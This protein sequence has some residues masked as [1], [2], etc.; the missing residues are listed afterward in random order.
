MN[1]F[2]ECC[3]KNGNT[4]FPC[5]FQ[6]GTIVSNY[7]YSDLYFTPY[8]FLSPSNMI[9]NLTISKDSRISNATSFAFISGQGT[10][11][12]NLIGPT[13]IVQPSEN[14]TIRI[15]LT[16]QSFANSTFT[17][18]ITGC[19][20]MFCILGRTDWD[21]INIKVSNVTLTSDGKF[22]VTQT[23]YNRA[24]G[25]YTQNSIDIQVD[26]LPTLGQFSVLPSSGYAWV[27]NF[28]LQAASFSLPQGVVY[29]QFGFIQSDTG[30][31]TPL[32]S[33]RITSSITT[34]LPSL[35]N[36]V[37]EV[38]VRALNQ[39]GGY[40]QAS[41]I[42]KVTQAPGITSLSVLEK[43]N[44][45]KLT[46]DVYDPSS[47]LMQAALGSLLLSQKNDTSLRPNTSYPSDY[48]PCNGNG[49]WITGKGCQCN[50][51]YRKRLD[52]SLSDEQ[53]SNESKLAVTIIS[54][55]ANL[56]SVEPSKSKYSTIFNTMV[57]ILSKSDLLNK[58]IK[59]QARNIIEA[60]L[61]NTTDIY[62]T[63]LAQAID[64]VAFISSGQQGLNDFTQ[65]SRMISMLSSMQSN[66]GNSIKGNETTKSNMTNFNL[67]TA[68]L[69]GS[70]NI[71]INMSNIQFPNSLAFLNNTDNYVRISVVEWKIPVYSWIS[72]YSNIKTG[73]TSIN[74][75]GITGN[76]TNITN[77]SQPINIT[78]PIDVSQMS[79]KNLTWTK[80]MY[81]DNK[82]N[83]FITSGM[84]LLRIDLNQSLG[85]CQTTHL[86]DFAM[87]IPIPLPYSG[88]IPIYVPPVILNPTTSIYEVHRSP[89]FWFTIS[90]T[91]ILG[92]L[93]CW[94]YCKERSENEL[95]KLMRSKQYVEQKDLFQDRTESAPIKGETKVE[96]VVDQE[97][98][99][100][101]LEKGAGE[102]KPIAVP[103]GMNESSMQAENSKIELQE[104]TFKDPSASPENK[105]DDLG[106]A[107]PESG[108]EN[109][110][111]RKKKGRKKQKGDMPLSTS[112]PPMATEQH[113]S[114][115][116]MKSGSG[117]Q[118][119]IPHPPSSLLIF[120]VTIILN[121]IDG[122]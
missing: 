38:A 73:I 59:T 109:K 122:A 100:A 7:S 50:Y 86:S 17:W 98:R 19:P 37:M 51:G 32:T 15:N 45:M 85:Y 93:C 56:S 52:C 75:D 97:E 115:E 72:G 44:K 13:R 43:Y 108:A 30:L 70:H 121:N 88:P 39:N 61:N 112:N 78:F 69:R 40:V 47:L 104:E 117:E 28:T 107:I 16:W 6:N 83:H 120:L 46:G 9:W 41:C 80:C 65:V 76:S 84:K 64:S 101:T 1:F 57:T 8:S 68:V 58:T 91:L 20:G 82:T 102:M 99:R 62:P 110:F 54:D 81:Y 25:K 2:W 90:I 79:T 74:I 24:T 12:L 67:Q 71:S 92:Y 31:F 35:N 4:N 105:K 55:C 49:I 29:Y 23:V 34:Q 48:S 60:C 116:Q 113:Q 114:P 63:A 21:M 10:P 94:A 22:T 11:A 27:T 53:F 18:T 95:A 119:P 36:S 89:L 3:V 42:I 111:K 77:L 26:T 106:Q 118:V 5:Y 103:S 14:I 66:I 96:N 87:G 33:N